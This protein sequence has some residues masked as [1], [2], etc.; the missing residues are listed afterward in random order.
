MLR[1]NERNVI[2]NIYWP[3][4]EIS[5]IRVKFEFSRHSSEKYSNT[6]FYENPFS[7]SQVIPCRWADGHDEANSRFSQFWV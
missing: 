2:T 3:S 4:R 7:G 1:R 6:K 5:M